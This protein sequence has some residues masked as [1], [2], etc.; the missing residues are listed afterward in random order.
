MAGLSA[1]AKVKLAVSPEEV[2]PDFIKTEVPATPTK[3]RVWKA[4]SELPV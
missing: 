2:L 4:Q 3:S 1:R